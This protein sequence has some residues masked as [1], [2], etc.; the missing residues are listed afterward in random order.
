MSG[1]VQ[2][3]ISKINGT[4]DSKGRLCIPAPYRQIL[5]AQNTPGLYILKSFQNAAL[6][7]FGQMLLDATQLRYSSDDPFFSQVTGNKAYAVLSRTQGLPLDEQGR[8]RLPDEL[9]EY[10]GLKDR[11][12]YVGMGQKFEIWEPARHEIV[13][14]KRMAFIQQMI[15]RDD[16]APLEPTP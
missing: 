15:E 6:E 14:A 8:V 5:A 13:D 3:F 7:G 16:A 10:A 9:I 12:V 11:V 1:L 2:P 4:L